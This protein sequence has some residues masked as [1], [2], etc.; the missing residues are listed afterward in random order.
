M[1]ARP[2]GDDMRSVGRLDIDRSSTN[3]GDLELYDR[4][5][6][7]LGERAAISLIRYSAEATVLMRLNGDAKLG[8]GSRAHR[9]HALQVASRVS[10][11]TLR[12]LAETETG[13][14]VEASLGT[15]HDGLRPSLVAALCQGAVEGAFKASFRAQATRAQVA[16]APDG[17]L[18][19]SVGRG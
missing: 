7:I 8:T 16:A 3:E 9:A 5:T 12:T 11:A 13:L 19:I 10:R 14:E 6:D 17:R 18:R 2:A 15:A 4:M 1:A